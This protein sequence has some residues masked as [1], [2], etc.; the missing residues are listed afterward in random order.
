MGCGFHMRTFSDDDRMLCLRVT[1]P[2]IG[3]PSDDLPRHDK[4]HGRGGEGNAGRGGTA[5]V[6]HQI[7]G[8]GR[9][10]R[11]YAEELLHT[12][13]LQLTAHDAGEGV[14]LGLGYVAD[15][16]GLGVELVAR[17]HGG[18]EWS[19]Y[20][21]TAYRQLD[22]GGYGIHAVG[23]EIVSGQVKILGVLGKVEADR[24]G[25]LA[26]GVDVLDALGHDLRLGTAH[27]GVKGY[28]LSVD[29]GEG[30]HVT[31]NEVDAP[32]S[33]ASQSLGQMP[34]YAADAEDRHGGVLQAEKAIL[35]KE[36]GGAGMLGGDGVTHGGLLCKSKMQ[37]QCGMGNEI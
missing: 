2:S 28:G 12:P 29:V 31:V 1:L 33:R 36:G 23:H 3:Q 22:L 37:N 32:H 25:H 13:L 4:P 8:N 20:G 24:G 30:Y 14:G 10:V 21:L 27:G 6:A 7:G 26:G 9:L 5:V 34:A 17:A 15:A 16:E 35:T 18:D 11:P 19:P